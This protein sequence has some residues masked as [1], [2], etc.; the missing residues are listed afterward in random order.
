MTRKRTLNRDVFIS[1]LGLGVLYYFL[2]R[3]EILVLASIYLPLCFFWKKLKVANHEFWKK[4]TSRLQS[5]TS[6]L[7]FGAIFVIALL[8]IALLFRL[9]NQKEKQEDSTFKDTDQTIDAMFF[10]VPW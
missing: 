3:T 7:L 4:F 8:P 2:L 9:F 1:A 5:V 10:E 6:P